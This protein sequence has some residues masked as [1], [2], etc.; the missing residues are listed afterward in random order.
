[1]KTKK[2][3]RDLSSKTV[4]TQPQY[5]NPTVSSYQSTQQQ[6]KSQPTIHPGHQVTPQQMNTTVQLPNTDDAPPEE[7]EF[8][9]PAFLR[10]RG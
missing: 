7:D 6:P 9:I 3:L 10:Q 8:D 1:M 2:R 5:G 4:Y